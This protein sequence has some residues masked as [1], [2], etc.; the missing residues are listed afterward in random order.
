MTV[1]HV[2]LAPSEFE[3]D[4]DS[5]IDGD[6]LDSSMINT[7]SKGSISSENSDSDASKSSDESRK[8]VSMATKQ[9]TLDLVPYSQRASST[10]MEPG[11]SSSTEGSAFPKTGAHSGRPMSHQPL[12]LGMTS[13][14]L[15]LY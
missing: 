15:F 3:Y 12:V 9:S 8:A 14:D 7:M 1:G 5:E 2:F 4:L 6:E 11:T 13:N 10:I